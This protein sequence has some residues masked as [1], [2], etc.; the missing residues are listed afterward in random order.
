MIKIETKKKT[1]GTY[2]LKYITIH[3]ESNIRFMEG[4]KVWTI[5]V[6]KVIS[7]NLM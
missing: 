1:F 6:S 7:I 5:K 2:E 4:V 3:G